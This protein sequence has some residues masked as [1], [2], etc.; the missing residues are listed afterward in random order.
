M[1]D[2]RSKPEDSPL[3]WCVQCRKLV[4][5]DGNTKLMKTVY[6]VH[7]TGIYPYCWCTEQGSEKFRPKREVS[8]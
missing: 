7:S 8:V 2:F 1:V 4:E 6:R 5:V 3:A